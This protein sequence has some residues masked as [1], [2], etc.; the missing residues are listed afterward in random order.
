M[1]FKPGSS[2][3]E[4]YAPSKDQMWKLTP[5]RL[6][7]GTKVDYAS[8]VDALRP[9]FPKPKILVEWARKAAKMAF[10]AIEPLLKKPVRETHHGKFNL[11]KIAGQKDLF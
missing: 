2:S 4:Q 3:G 11:K 7:L 9:I 8:E 5:N 6:N 1:S 10:K